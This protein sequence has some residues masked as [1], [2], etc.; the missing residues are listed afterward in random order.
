MNTKSQQIEAA[1][2]N[3]LEAFENYACTLENSL[4]LDPDTPED[5]ILCVRRFAGFCDRLDEVKATVFEEFL[6]Y[7]VNYYEYFKDA[8]KQECLD[9]RSNSPKQLFDPYL[10]DYVMKASSAED[11]LDELTSSDANIQYLHQQNGCPSTEHS[12][13]MFSK[14][15]QLISQYKHHNSELKK[16]ISKTKK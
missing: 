14:L 3:S 5:L 8:P 15:N 4:K 9:H 6:R 1:Y 10:I 12:A 7:A 16:Q 11:F 13:T 2:D